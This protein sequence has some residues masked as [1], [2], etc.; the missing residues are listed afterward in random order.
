MPDLA[1]DDSKCDLD[2]ARKR[3]QSRTDF[4]LDI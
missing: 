4:L 2:L 3:Y 1:G